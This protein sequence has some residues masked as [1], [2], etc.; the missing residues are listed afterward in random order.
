MT[1]RDRRVTKA[2]KGSLSAEQGPAKNTNTISYGRLRGS[3]STG[4]HNLRRGAK[5]KTTRRQMRT[6]TAYSTCGLAAIRKIHI[7]LGRNADAAC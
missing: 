2:Y 7:V 3:S 5:R 4:A 6:G 1:T